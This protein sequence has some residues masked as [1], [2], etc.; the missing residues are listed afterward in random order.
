MTSLKVTSV[1]LIGPAL[2]LGVLSVVLGCYG[3]P[4]S[5][6]AGVD[7]GAGRGGDTKAGNGGDGGTGPA[8]ADGA[9]GGRLTGIGGGSTESG[10]VGGGAGGSAGVG[11]GSGAGAGGSGG[12]GGLSGTGAN[13]TGGAAGHGGSRITCS[14]PCSSTAY[15]D[16]GTCKSRF[17]EFG[18]G[19]PVPEYI[20]S[21]TDGALWFSEST[22]DGLG[23]VGG[24]LGRISTAGTISQFT[25]LTES[26]A[27]AG[28]KAVAAGITTG[29][30][31]NVWFDLITSTGKAYVGVLS[32]GGTVSKYLFSM[33]APRLGRIAAD[34]DGN[35]WVAKMTNSPSTASDSLVV[36]TSTGVVTQ[37][38]VPTVSGAYGVTSGPDGNIWIA[39]ASKNAIARITP[40][41]TVTEYSTSA[42]ALNIASGADGNLWF[43]EP[44]ALGRS[45]TEGRI[46][47]FPIQ[48]SANA[49]DITRGPDGNMWFTETSSAK[50][51]F[52]TASGAVTEYSVPAIP[53]GIATGP[54]G[55][56]WFTERDAGKVARLLLP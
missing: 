14:V 17:T 48:P 20:A 26:E 40:T 38:L 45:T 6:H 50:I 47:E 33:T 10:G 1:S 16:A 52:I 37:L 19:G 29:A 25:L 46:I 23:S 24:K 7:G 8:G 36:T 44:G 11:G 5:G 9:N 56:I 53:Y 18:V 21:G 51:G 55:N 13:G 39:E 15:C 31:G 34:P 54:D 32:P 22:D 4:R 28:T 43:T 35:L 12:S 41:G 2:A 27:S 30:D 3:T 42:Q 49:W